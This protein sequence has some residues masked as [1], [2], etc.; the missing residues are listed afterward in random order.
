LREFDLR[1]RAQKALKFFAMARNG[2]STD[3]ILDQ[4]DNLLLGVDAELRPFKRHQMRNGAAILAIFAN[5]PLR[6][7]SAQLVFGVS[8]F[9]EQNQWIIRIPIHKTQIARPELFEFP[10]HPE[11]GRFVDAVILGESSPAMLPVLRDKV[12]SEQRQLFVL[13]DGT[14]ASATYVPRIFKALTG[15]S[16]TCLRVMLYTDAVEHHG[17]EGIELAMSSANHSSRLIVNQHYICELVASTHAKNLRSKRQARRKG[18]G[19]AG[20]LK[21]D[22]V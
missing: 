11:C 16:F 15:D 12:L 14:P 19:Y 1:K 10:L 7:A 8:L 3:K 4:A 21:F 2:N 13:R 6:N 17:V 18:I 5:A 20:R 9:W 22:P